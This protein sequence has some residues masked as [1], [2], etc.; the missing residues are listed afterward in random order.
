MAF[1]RFFR[2][3]GF[4]GLSFHGLRASYA[5]TMAKQGVGLQTIA[6]RL[7]HKSVHTTILC[8]PKESPPGQASLTA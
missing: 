6:E 2:R 7:G 4:R 1:G 5:T 8:V 3:L